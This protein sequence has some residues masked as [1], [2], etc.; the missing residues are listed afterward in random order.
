MMIFLRPAIGSTRRA[1]TFR[2]LPARRV[3][4][5]ERG[6]AIVLQEQLHLPLRLFQLCRARPR[7][8]DSLLER[9]YRLLQGKAPAL[10]PFDHLGEA[11]HDLLVA[12]V[13]RWRGAL[14]HLLGHGTAIALLRPRRH[15][16]F[17]PSSGGG[18]ATEVTSVCSSPSCRRTRTRSPGRTAWARSRAC[19]R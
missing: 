8:P 17:C 18:P 19:P 5:A 10:Q 13:V 6:D 12:R 15:G 7:Q 4:V 2:D 16:Q 11:L 14:G 3:V 9:R 1:E